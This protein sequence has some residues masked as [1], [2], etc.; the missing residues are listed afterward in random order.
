MAKR[1]S[2]DVAFLLIDGWD[3]LGQ[4][5]QL[6]DTR[7]AVLE[8][9]DAL[10]DLYEEHTFTGVRRAELTQQGFLDD[11]ANSAHEALSTGPGVARVLVYGMEGTVT[12]AG[13]E[14][15]ASAVQVNYEQL[16]ARESLHKANARY[17]TA[18]PVEHGRIV[19]TLKPAVAT[20]VTS[21]NALD[22]GASSTGGAGYFAYTSGGEA[23]VRMRHSSDGVTWATLFTFARAN[24]SRGAERLMTTGT[25]ERYVDMDYTTATATGTASFNFFGG[26]VR[27]LTT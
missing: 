21:A 19:R 17:L 26:L 6:E 13:F 27:G 10:G 14:G 22:N 11:G 8:R 24:A 3:V 2:A 16:M 20:G 23:N 25:I 4:Q 15:W 18:G 12:G 1:G 7:S 9:S 5:T